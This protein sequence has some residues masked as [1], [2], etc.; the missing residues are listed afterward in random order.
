M[1]SDSGGNEKRLMIMTEKT[2]LILAAGLGTR[3]KGGIKQLSPVGPEGE[4]LMEYSIYDAVKAGCTKAV[5]IIRRELEQAFRE[6][7]G[8]K[9]EKY[10][11]VSNEVG[12]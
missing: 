10:I 1:P 5:F 6:K 9:L 2:L 8:L 11:K 3:F 4:L 7:L 12:A